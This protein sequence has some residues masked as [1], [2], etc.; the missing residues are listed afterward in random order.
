MLQTI[1]WP[2][3]LMFFVAGAGLSIDSDGQWG[4]V[5]FLFGL[6][7]FCIY[8]SQLKAVG[9]THNLASNYSLAWIGFF[10]VTLLSCWVFRYRG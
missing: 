1:I 6:G 7:V 4:L 3:A 10:I 8:I 9:G 5:G 2:L